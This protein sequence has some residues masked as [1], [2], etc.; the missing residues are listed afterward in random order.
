MSGNTAKFGVWEVKGCWRGKGRV[1]S[2]D[3][4]KRYENMELLL[5]VEFT[6]PYKLNGPIP[7]QDGCMVPIK[8]R[9]LNIHN[10]TYK[11][12]PVF[13]GGTTLETRKAQIIIDTVLHV[14][15]LV[16]QLIPWSDMA[17]LQS[18]SGVE[19]VYWDIPVRGD[20]E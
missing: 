12:L 8:G 9:P 14:C 11:M 16:L 19:L 5:W 18:C 20:Q 15:L 17:Q 3:L 10:I 13:R 7:L 2:L 1:N 6:R 4:H